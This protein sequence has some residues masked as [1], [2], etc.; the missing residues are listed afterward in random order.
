LVGNLIIDVASPFCERLSFGQT[1]SP[2]FDHKKYL[3]SMQNTFGRRYGWQI[4]LK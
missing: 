2:G 3:L 1:I 4:I